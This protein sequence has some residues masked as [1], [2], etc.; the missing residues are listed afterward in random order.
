MATSARRWQL[1]SHSATEIL[2]GA[3][4]D[5]MNHIR[6]GA[7]HRE[8][9]GSDLR[10]RWLGRPSFWVLALDDGARGFPVGT[11]L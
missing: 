6:A 1:R 3:T 4:C 2:D 5:Q 8:G 11:G 7:R 10:S 9:W